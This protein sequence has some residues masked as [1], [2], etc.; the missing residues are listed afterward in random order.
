MEVDVDEGGG[1]EL[2]FL[3]QKFALLGLNSPRQSVQEDNED[4]DD[5]SFTTPP[6]SPTF[7]ISGVY[8]SKVDRD[9]F[10]ALANVQIDSLRFPTVHRWHQSVLFFN[11]E[12]QM[13]WP[14]FDSPRAKSHSKMVADN[15]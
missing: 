1:D 4:S 5:D 12:E 3:C 2:D 8:P 15:H 7:F 6:S 13:K 9:V 11:S 14:N 10:L